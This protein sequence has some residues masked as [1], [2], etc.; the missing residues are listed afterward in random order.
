[1]S[2]GQRPVS[3]FWACFFSPSLFALLWTLKIKKTRIWILFFILF[4][5]ELELYYLLL[6]ELE[7]LDANFLDEL[8]ILVA[9][10]LDELFVFGLLL[11]ALMI[12]NAFIWCVVHIYL[13]YRWTSEFNLKN[14]GYES[15]AE[16]TK[17]QENSDKLTDPE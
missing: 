4:S 1:M 9:N 7:T 13:M 2:V 6:N 15:K 3:R 5:I 14:F 8:T 10:F 17:A 12:F 11:S 16:W